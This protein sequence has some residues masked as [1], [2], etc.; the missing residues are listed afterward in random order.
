MSGFVVVV[1]CIRLCFTVNGLFG[2]NVM[3]FW[4]SEGFIGNLRQ[5]IDLYVFER[6]TKR[7]LNIFKLK[8]N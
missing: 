8:R 6:K 3:K 2:R 1:E 4:I 5:K 7:I